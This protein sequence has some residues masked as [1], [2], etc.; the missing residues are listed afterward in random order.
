MLKILKRKL[1]QY[2]P[3][4]V[5]EYSCRYE[6]IDETTGRKKVKLGGFEEFGQKT[7]EFLKNAIETFYPECKPIQAENNDQ[8]D[9]KKTAAEYDQ[10]LENG[11]S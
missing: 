5:F 8:N 3:D 7:L 4:Q 11:N 1:K 2:F 9:L 6:G 10:I